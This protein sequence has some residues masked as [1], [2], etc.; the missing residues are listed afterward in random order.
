[1]VSFN[2][3]VLQI[4]SANKRC[5]CASQKVHYQLVQS[6]EYNAGKDHEIIT[7]ETTIVKQN[8]KNNSNIRIKYWNV[9]KNRTLVSPRKDDQNSKNTTS[10]IRSH[11]EKHVGRRLEHALRRTYAEK[12]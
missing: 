11:S 5:D 3:G 7:K 8:Y 6:T 9:K 4:L 12:E 10:I 1:M 2:H